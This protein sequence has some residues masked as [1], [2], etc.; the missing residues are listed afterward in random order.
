[1]ATMVALEVC[2]AERGVITVGSITR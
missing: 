1:L 2:S